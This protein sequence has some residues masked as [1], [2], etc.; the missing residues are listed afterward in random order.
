MVLC[1]GLS[2]AQCT[3]KRRPAPFP[4]Y[5]SQTPISHGFLVRPHQKK[6]TAVR[7]ASFRHGPNTPPQKHQLLLSPRPDRCSSATS[8]RTEKRERNGLSCHG[9]Q[10]RGHLAR[11]SRHRHR[12]RSCA[13]GNVV[14]NDRRLPVRSRRGSSNC[15]GESQSVDRR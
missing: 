2:M 5:V 12:E 3:K 1:K 15:R 10:E 11:T 13:R 8:I 9:R 7:R 14:Q 6:Y 4:C